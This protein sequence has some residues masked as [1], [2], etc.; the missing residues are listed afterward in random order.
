MLSV[1]NIKKDYSLGKTVVSALKGINLEINKGEFCAIIGP[2]GSGKTTLLNL[3][4]LIDQPTKGDI[5]LNGES[6][7]DLKVKKRTKIRAKSIGIIFQDFFLLP[8]FNVF[9]NI[10]LALDV[11]GLKLSKTEKK[12]KILDVIERIGLKDH[13]K[14]RPSELSGGQRQRV[15]IARA[16]IKNP[17]IVIADEPTSNLD[18]KTAKEIMNLMMEISNEENA[19]IIS[20]HDSRIL[21]GMNRIIHLNDGLITKDVNK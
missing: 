5:C 12:D 10:A 17:Q 18:T 14:H 19:F 13:L 11:D 1:R 3:I 21:D 15:S 9:D 16:L 7:V 4:S 8:V 6:V 20:T 2:S